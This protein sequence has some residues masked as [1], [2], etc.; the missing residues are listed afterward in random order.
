MASKWQGL[1]FNPISV[2]YEKHFGEKIYKIPVTVVDNCPNRMGL[3]GMTTC[4]FCDVWGSAAHSESFQMPLEDQIEKYSKLLNKRYKANSFLVYFQ[5]Y[6][7]SFTKIL[8]L[9]ESF[10]R[11]L[12]YPFVR[13]IV[14]G[15]RPDCLSKSVIDL[16]N[17]YS[18][19]TFVSVELGVQSFNNNHLEFMK[20]GHTGEDSLKAIHRIAKESTVDLGIHLIIGSPGETEAQIK[21]QALICNDLPIT[22][23]KLHNLHVLKKTKLEELYNIGE[24]APID[25]QTYSERVQIFIENLSPRI[26]LHRLAAYS[27]RWDELVAPMWT[28]NKMGT[29]QHIID[30]LHERESYQ[31]K[32]YVTQSDGEKALKKHL[33]LQSHMPASLTV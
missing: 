4:S 3:K 21:E 5:A 18:Q 6:T 7:N 28:A 17:E 27:P 29:H 30:F 26:Y 14:I 12:K 32:A 15:T 31:S 24:F 33:F 8:H 11:A 10:D 9:R 19:K 1:P 2:K 23:V 22:N 13:G 20:R 25:L 16:W